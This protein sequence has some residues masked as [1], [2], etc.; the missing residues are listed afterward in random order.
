V[1]D[2]ATAPRPTPRPTPPLTI[3]DAAAA[4]RAGTTTSVELVQRAV[5]V[6]DAHDEAVGMFLARHTD[7]ALAAAEAAD[8]AIAAGDDLGPLHGIPLGIKDIITTGEGPTTGQSLVHDTAAMSGDAVVVDR[9]R[10]AG[11]IMM[12]KL[13]TMEFAIGA[14]DTTKPF[15]LPRNPWNLEHWAGGSSSGSGSAVAAGAVLGALGTDTAGS[16]RIPAAFCGVSG[17]MGTFGR[18]PK[19]GCIPLGYSLDH[20]GPLA[21]SAR[22]CA[23]MFDVLAG[24]HPSDPT[25]LDVPASSYSARLT[26]DLTG[27][28]IGADRLARIGGGV[29]DPAVPG[30]FAAA[31]EALAG[32]GAEIVDIELPHYAEMGAAMWVI[33]LSE[34]FAYHRPDLATRWSDYGAPTRSILAG[35]VQYSAAD[36]VQAQRVRRAGVRAIAALYEDVD[37]IVTPTAAV[38]AT[39]LAA[40][41]QLT[42]S[43]EFGAI[44]TPYWDAAGNPVLSVPAGFTAAGLPLAIQIAGRPFDEAL[45]LRAGDAFQRVTDW[46]LRTPA[47]LTEGIAA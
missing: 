46:H 6:A 47:L 26:G 33:M 35:A 36:Y 9:L 25:T 10:S 21:R 34:A 18:V 12:G 16:I 14:P 45:V 41:A 32:R 7:S 4:L 20:I 29:E 39:A 24:P 15:P 44:Y 19:S 43:E 22:D 13:T 3:A 38:G 30:A 31:L 1:T 23:L 37:L 8:T 11:G 17:L 28:R 5:A 2:L 40:M 42:V 27:A